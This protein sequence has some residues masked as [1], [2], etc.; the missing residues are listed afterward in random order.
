[1]PNTL[2]YGDNLDVMRNHLDDASIDLVYLDPPFN[3]NRDYNVLFKEQSGMDSP[4]Q[5]KA[6]G[7]T[8]KWA[9]AA[10][11]WANFPELCPN[12]RVQNLMQG[13]VDTLGCNDVTAYLVMMAPRLYHLHRVLKPTGSLYLHCDPTASHYLKCLLDAIFEPRNFR[14]EIIWRRSNSHNSTTL[15]YGPIHDTILFYTKSD[16]F[17]FHPGTRPYTRGYIEDR[18]THEDER[19]RF[20]TNYLTGPGTRNGESGKIW[21]GFDPTTAGRHW[22]IPKSLREYLPE[23]GA[24]MKSHQQLDALYA[25]NLI[26]FPKKTGGQPMYKQYIGGGTA[27]QDIWAYQPNTRGVLYNTEE[28][29]DEDVKYLEGE[30]EKL[31]YP[32]QKPSGLLER[33]VSTSSNPGDTVLDPFCGC[34]TAIIAA[35]ALGR[36]WVGIDITPIATSLII[37]R[38]A[39]KFQ[40]RDQQQVKPADPDFARA[41]AVKGLPEDLDAARKLFH[42]NPK[43]FEM[44]AV[45]KIPM[46]PQDKKG[47]DGGI[48]GVKDYYVGDKKPIRAVAQ[49]K[50][51]KVGVAQ[52]RDLIGVMTREKATL[53]LFVCLEPPTQNMKDEAIHAGFYTLPLTG[54]KVPQVQIRT[55]S[56][57][58]DGRAFDLPHIQAPVQA[59]AEAAAALRQMPMDL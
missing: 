4:A 15:Q 40:L 10:L 31:G 42:D 18:F 16:A 24:G 57:L 12:T 1:M 11:D 23:E 30:Q 33:I 48:D 27:Y 41:F 35:Q 36:H 34:G 29:I 6:F 28:C 25:Q 13:F 5:I 3:S 9:N 54:R 39:D 2:Y 20:Q 56:D 19:G 7:D 14:N 45:G 22:A 46:K 43:D 38:L 44:W 37:D 17:T 58:L 8:W 32:T 52:V 26:V 50:G 47:A 55:I 59:V 51:G 53:G 21:K 49:V